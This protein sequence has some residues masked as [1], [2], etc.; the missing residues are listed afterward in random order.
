MAGLLCQSKECQHLSASGS[1]FP[2]ALFGLLLFGAAGLERY[3]K[4]ILEGESGRP[5]RI[6][7]IAQVD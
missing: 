2:P 1:P 7:T 3:G 6:Q 5:G 4:R